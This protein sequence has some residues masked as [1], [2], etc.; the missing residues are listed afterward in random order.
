[1]QA[2][3]RH[4]CDGK[5]GGYHG[6][7]RSNQCQKA[8][9]RRSPRCGPSAA[10]QRPSTKPGKTS[11]LSVNFSPLIGPEHLSTSS[12]GQYAMKNLRRQAAHSSASRRCR[13]HP[14]LARAAKA[15][16]TNKM[17]LAKLMAPVGGL[18]AVLSP[19]QLENVRPLAR[20]Q[21]RI[22]SKRSASR[23]TRHPPAKAAR[24][25]RSARC[26]NHGCPVS[27]AAWLALAAPPVVERLARLDQGVAP[28]TPT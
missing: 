13:G 8:L 4:G 7:R 10:R 9:P 22:N 2:E 12:A 16:L 6:A 14:A 23:R 24:W 11:S 26:P 20:K 5:A 1:M 21:S 27:T 25:R 19:L 3:T 28:P 15:V 18:L 17:I